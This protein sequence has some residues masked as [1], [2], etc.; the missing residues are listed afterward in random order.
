MAIISKDSVKRAH[1]NKAQKFHLTNA[2]HIYST[3]QFPDPQRLST[4]KTFKSKQELQSIS[5]KSIK[6]KCRRKLLTI[7]SSKPEKELKYAV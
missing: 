6:T 5:P 4:V 2:I 3:P 1:S 7:N